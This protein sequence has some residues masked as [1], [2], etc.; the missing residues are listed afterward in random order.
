MGKNDIFLLKTLINFSILFCIVLKYFVWLCLVWSCMVFVWSSSMSFGRLRCHFDDMLSK[1]LLWYILLTW[2]FDDMSS[3]CRQW[4]I[5]D[6]TFWRHVI[7][8]SLTTFCRHVVHVGKTKCLLSVFGD[9]SFGMFR[10]HFFAKCRPDIFDMSPTCRRMS[11]RHVI[12]GVSATWRDADI[13][14]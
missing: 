8:M 7:K 10:R 3:K 5:S 4:H 13:S 1:Y 14:N 9:M 2:H 6:M 11:G 12:W